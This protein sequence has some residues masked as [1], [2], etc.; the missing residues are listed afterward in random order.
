MNL[1]LRGVTALPELFLLSG[2]PIYCRIEKP[3][4][5]YPVKKTF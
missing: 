4:A 2:G 3:D 5:G 1:K